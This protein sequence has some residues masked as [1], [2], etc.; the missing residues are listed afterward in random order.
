MRKRIS[1]LFLAL[2]LC[3]GLA[4]PALAADE[5]TPDG[6]SM[7]VTLPDGAELQ[8]VS[9]D[10]PIRMASSVA[11][12]DTA[13]DTVM[14][15]VIARS[16]EP[17]SLQL[18]AISF[19]RGASVTVKNMR[20][21][22]NSEDHQVDLAKAYAF[23]DPDGDGVYDQWIY[24]F[25]KTPP[26]VPLSEEGVDY[27]PSE[28]G[29]YSDCAYCTQDDQLKFDMQS[30]VDTVTITADYL[31]QVF[32][33]N[34]LVLLGVEI[35][36]AVNVDPLT[37][38]PTDD[39]TSILLFL[40]GE[41]PA[42]PETPAQPEKP[43]E[44]LAPADAAPTSAPVLVNGE[45]TA[46]DAYE[47][48]G[49]NYFKLRDLAYVLSGTDKQFEIAWDGAANAISLTSGKAYTAVGGEMTSKGAGRQ[50]AAPTSAKI[51]LDGREVSF[52]AYEIGGNNYFKLRD[53]GE[54]FDFG[55]DWDEAAQ[56]IK[57][58]TSKGYTAG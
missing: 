5:A 44:P 37:A 19:P 35:W 7:Q 13:T 15:H 23:S 42:E 1:A 45:K 26:V 10:Y 48:S 49:N 28:N 20:S 55:V 21:D 57:I 34:T 31:Y 3:L 18:S 39:G 40:P 36:T 14:R 8:R 24:D 47:I 32:G 51:L 2:A 33:P 9:G 52:T 16:D 46:F 58:D 41:T 56:T 29:R 30:P 4:V 25:T 50:T 53:V 11:L 17:E 12:R 43:A 27:L 38:L 6:A 22:W 54:A